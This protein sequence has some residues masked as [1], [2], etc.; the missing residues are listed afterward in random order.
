MIRV[1]FLCHGRILKSFE[2]SRK[3]NGFAKQ[4]GA[5]YTT[6]TPNILLILESE[7]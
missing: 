4:K 3:I 5:Y 1:L 6:S 7:S 2:K